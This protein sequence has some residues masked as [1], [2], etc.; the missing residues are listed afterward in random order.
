MQS[1]AWEGEQ[2]TRGAKGRLSSYG[3]IIPLTLRAKKQPSSAGCVYLG[4]RGQ[5][6]L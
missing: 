6:R 5:Q 2:D 3:M 1:R 4:F